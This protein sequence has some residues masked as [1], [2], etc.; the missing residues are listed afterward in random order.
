MYSPKEHQTKQGL[1]KCFRTLTR[2]SKVYFEDTFKGQTPLESWV[3]I[4]EK[5]VDRLGTG[6]ESKIALGTVNAS[7]SPEERGESVAGQHADYQ[8]IAVDE[9]SKVDTRTIQALVDTNSDPMNFLALISN[10]TR[11]S[12]FFYDIWGPAKDYWL[13]VTWNAEESPRVSATKTKALEQQF[14][15]DSNEYR[16]G[17]LG[18]F[19]VTNEWQFISW[20]DCE[21][22]FEV[23]RFEPKPENLIIMGIDPSGGGGGDSYAYVLMQGG[24]C[25]TA[26]KFM[27]N[28]KE[29]TAKCLLVARDYS[30]DKIAIDANGIGKGPYDDFMQ[31]AKYHHFE[32]HGVISH[33]RSL[34]RRQYALVRDEIWLKMREA[35]KASTL[36]LS[37]FD[38]VRNHPLRDELRRAFTRIQ[39]K[40]DVENRLKLE[41]KREYISNGEQSPD[42]ADALALTFYL[43]AKLYEPYNNNLVRQEKLYREEHTV[44]HGPNA[45]TGF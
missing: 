27:G 8:L 16:I 2:M 10:P 17:V 3:I 31:Y 26:G 35:L 20:D 44:V 22:A 43:N 21:R 5:T 6:K 32:V 9:A 41:S 45:W 33:R 34:N 7:A 4:R 19:P 1:W 18:L 14:G 11:L 42:L 39:L 13:P 23:I 12:G 38:E 30:V 15:R 29:C 28:T 36:D 25:L 24:K 40:S 37:W